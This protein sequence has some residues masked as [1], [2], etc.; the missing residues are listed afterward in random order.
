MPNE[1]RCYAGCPYLGYHTVRDTRHAVRDTMPRSM[2][3][4]VVCRAVRD[5]VQCGTPCRAGHLAV[6]HTPLGA[7]EAQRDRVALQRNVEQQ[8]C[9]VACMS[10]C[11][12]ARTHARVRRTSFAHARS[13]VSLGSSTPMVSRQLNCAASARFETNCVRAYLVHAHHCHA[14]RPARAQTF[15][16]T[17]TR[18]RGAEVQALPVSSQSNAATHTIV[19][20]WHHAATCCS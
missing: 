8:V 14:A 13:C 12:H 5:T 16:H 17:S 6:K 10:I 15:V 18:T 2:P 19:E 1:T 20:S 9:E 4:D 3:C 7:P 11:V